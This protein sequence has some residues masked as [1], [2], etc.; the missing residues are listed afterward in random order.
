MDGSA[1]QAGFYYQ[2]NIAALKII[3]SLFFESDIKY[4]Q[5]ENYDRGNHI[6]DIIINR[7]NTTEFIQVKWSEDDENNYTLYNLISKTEDKKSLFRQLAD[8]FKSVKN[9]EDDFQIVL[10]STKGISN[11]LRPSKNIK[12]G[13]K[14]FL[15]NI[16]APIQS[17]D[18]Y[19]EKIKSI[20]QYQPVL[21]IVR[22]ETGLTKNEFNDFLNRL[23][24]QLKQEPLY[25]VK[26]A[27]EVK[28]N[29]LGIE[30]KLIDKLLTSVVEWSI[31]G[32]KITK[33]KVLK[34][35]DLF[36]RF[37]DKLSHFFKIVDEKY[38][39]GNEQLLKS[40]KSSIDELKGGY[41]L[42]EGLPGIGKSTALTKFKQQHKEIAFT[43]YCFIPNSRNN[44]GE[45]RHKSNYFLKSMCV[46]IENR[47]PQVDFPYR[48]SDDYESKLSAYIGELSKLNRKIIFVID[49]LDHVHRD[50]GF[51]ENSLLT[52]IKGKLP[53]NIFI[54]V[55]TQYKSVL[56][57]SVIQQINLDSRRYIVAKGFTQR[58]IKEY[59]TNKGIDH[60]EI[61]GLVEKVSSGIPLYLHYISELL[62][63]VDKYEYKDVLKKLP[64]LSNGGIDTYHEYLYSNIEFSE[65]AKW[66]L[67][68]LA[69]RKE[70]TSIKLINEILQTIG[71]DTDIIKV[72]EVMNSFSHLLKRNDSG[73]Y[74]IFHN[75]FREFILFK[76]GDIK[77][78]FSE[79]L[80]NY[81][82]QNPNSDE[83]YRNYFSLLYDTE[84]FSKI[85]TTISVDWIK[86]AW[87]NLRPFNEIKHNVEIAHNAAVEVLN[88]SEFIRI[89]FL[90]ARILNIE[91]NL[92][93]SNI[94]FPTLF[95]KAGRVKNS[96]RALWDGD[97]L[98]GSKEYF[99]HYLSLYHLKFNKLLPATIL[100]QG[101]G[102]DTI[103]S[104]Y[105]SLLQ[106]LKADIQI[107]KN[108]VTVFEAIDKITWK[109]NDDNRR[110]FKK[111]DYSKKKNNK[112][113][114]KIK[115]KLI[116]Y[117][118]LHKEY[119]KLSLLKEANLNDERIAATN[120]IALAKF[121]IEDDKETALDILNEV[122]FTHISKFK[123][124]ALISHFSSFLTFNQIIE[125]FP[126]PEISLPNFEDKIVAQGQMEFKIKD[127]IVSLFE[128]LKAVWIFEPKLIKKVELRVSILSDPALGIYNSILN[129]SELWKNI[130]TIKITD[131]A[132]LKYLKNSL[133]ELYIKHPKY[134]QK[135][136]FGLFDMDSDGHF[137]GRSLYKITNIIFQ[138]ALEQLSENE[139]KQFID[140]WFELEESE[141]GYRHHKVGIEF[142]KIINKKNKDSFKAEI[143]KIIEHSEALVRQDEDTATLLEHL[144][145]IAETYGICDFQEQF[146][147]L[148]NEFIVIAFG[149]GHRKDYQTSYITS[150][151]E[152]IHRTDKENSLNRLEE[153][154]S[155]QT[156]L[157]YAGNG[158]MNH[159]CKSDLISFAGKYYPGLAFTLLEHEENNIGRNEALSI[160]LKPFIEKASKEEI[161]LLF[162]VLKTIPRCNVGGTSKGEFLDL[163]VQL[164]SHVIEIDFKDYL[165][166]IL[167]EVKFNIMVELEE[168]EKFEEFYGILKNNDLDPADFSLPE[169]E[170]KKEKDKNG[171]YR[172]KFL[173]HFLKPDKEHFLELF[174]KSYEDFDKKLESLLRVRIENKRRVGIRNEFYTFKNIFEDFYKSLS[175]QKK[176]K[177]FQ[178]IRYFL[179]F[180]DDI[181]NLENNSYIEKEEIAFCFKSLCTKIDKKYPDVKV[182]DYIE[183]ECDVNKLI[184]E[185]QNNINDSRERIIS[186]ILS[187]ED[188]NEIISK[189]S[190]LKLERMEDFLEKWV[191]GNN[192]SKAIL[193]LANRLVRINPGKAKQMLDVIAEKEY[194]NFLFSNRFTKE[195]L[196]F[197]VIETF[198]K[199]DEEFGKR[200]LFKSFISQK[201][202]YSYELLS[203]IDKLTEY[204]SYFANEN[205]A[206]SYFD[207]N[208]EY[209]KG[210]AEG[211]PNKPVD[212][213]FVKKYDSKIKFSK[214]I[215]DYIINLF[216]YPV[217]K[218][219]ELALQAVFD[220][221]LENPKYIETI[222]KRDFNKLSYNEVEHTLTVLISLASVKPDLLVKFK[223]DLWSFA[224]IK[225]F[226]IIQLLK[227]LLSTI[228]KYNKDF[229]TSDEKL[230]LKNLNQPSSLII[231]KEFKINENGGRFLHSEFQAHI[232][233]LIKDNDLCDEQ[234][235]EQVYTDLK[236][237]KNLGNYDVENEGIV[238]QNYN[239][240]TNFDTIEIHSNY[241]EEVKNS[242]NEILYKKI[243]RSCFE[244]E[245]IDELSLEF[246]LYDPTNLLY[247]P[248]TRPEYINWL[249]KSSPEDFMR[250]EDLENIS[251]SFIQREKEFITL[252]ESGSQRLID[253]YRETKFSTY[254]EVYAFLKKKEFDIEF[255]SLQYDPIISKKNQFALEMP[256]SK[257]DINTFPVKGILPILEVSRNNFRGEKHL[258]KAIIAKEFFKMLDYGQLNLSDLL[259]TKSEAKK[260]IS[261]HWQN[262]YTSGRRR[263]K[264]SSEGFGLK[265]NKSFLK[266]FLEKNNF[267]LCLN[268][269]VSRSNTPYVNE[270]HMKWKSFQKTVVVKI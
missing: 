146:V 209:N 35:L 92:D 131:S 141:D 97:F 219:R 112:I 41:I 190:I 256:N 121:F 157:A 231:P 236:Q 180:R 77:N 37:E 5:L 12:V 178:I 120:K 213:S 21:E 75:S 23:F 265:I 82:E 151:L 193:T 59:L 175:K 9:A 210:L 88:L 176:I 237:N 127:D 152:A 171:T 183:N 166:I 102:K 239:I 57:E 260:I 61:L 247:K 191:T 113:N 26:D 163:S 203:S 205:V 145:E 192:Y 29:L 40:I 233:Y 148:Y 244:S 165:P 197:N 34:Q 31:S 201:G 215:V 122:N 149:V 13:L 8:G 98:L 27:I 217:I 206:E 185:I 248:V 67:T 44:F 222:L 235:Q 2:N 24:F 105:D 123:L 62:L 90:R 109:K 87:R 104:S 32:E 108:P 6:D 84:N 133:T 270:S 69:Y 138:L 36:Q 135:R 71:V 52:Q 18:D 218:V 158:R 100:S 162:A 96:L 48:Y 196:G 16:L 70:N 181:V 103:D 187:D 242:L 241:Y 65:Y 54:I 51:S 74:S 177:G 10:Y 155:I 107:D 257:R 169:V 249:P 164:L 66:V 216:D 115:E 14:D 250:F 220:M 199:A 189:S 159:I 143:L 168:P 253:G 118:L 245:F 204:E 221:L 132:K 55:S 268:F 129:L 266:K 212:Y 81:Y 111:T 211:L 64:R 228:E 95:L 38:Y 150:A 116:N 110:D 179:E 86:T 232:L 261:I 140:Y 76:T 186:S 30:K 240:N 208:L 106:S 60:S 243:K 184:D 262:A 42:I 17:A 45:L 136:S 147:K 28:F 20:K 47:F 182:E 251:E 56:S 11:A 160:V 33:E 68:F 172:G 89:S 39:V 224:H 246:R 194:D 58:K 125:Y 252:F 117:L 255:E 22:E 258:S 137:I 259:Q 124:V 119:G 142:A 80:I 227:S 7:E 73:N 15:Q 264:P 225:H 167:K 46:G 234:I 188:I 25:R 79:S 226:N 156:Q 91:W 229:L 214:V 19:Y 49:G 130:K 207:A 134:L 173:S 170:F 83:A 128:L 126:K 198:I 63:K 1:P 4:I 78:K 269:E 174:I 139:L 53:D 3:E 101:L 153:V 114:S 161:P 99:Y 238:H 72:K 93:N 94:D 43:Y 223:K 202:R 267:D 263:Y 50:L 154:L 230:K 254:F 85:L 200:Y 144:G 195:K